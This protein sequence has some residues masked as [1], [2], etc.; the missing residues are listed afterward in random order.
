MKAG[1]LILHIGLIAIIIVLGIL[2]YRSIVTPMR[3]EDECNR[4]RDACAEKLKVIRTLQ[5]AH[6]M[7]YGVYAA[8]L[9]SLIIDLQQGKQPVV[10]KEI[11]GEIPEDMTEAMAVKQ[12]LMRRDTVYMNPLEKLREEKKLFKVNSEGDTIYITNDE[13]LFELKYIPVK[14]KEGQPRMQFVSNADTIRRSGL[15]VPVFEVKVDLKDLLWDLD[16]QAVVNK[17]A[18]IERVEDA[19]GNK[20]YAGWKIG[21][22]EDPITDGNFE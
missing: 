21:S 13:E 3:F 19:S 6:K 12:G 15:L 4:R 8:N 7:A 11:L 2:V 18:G 16:Q 22:M 5:E 1:K 20:K 9:D 17:I 14:A 10:K